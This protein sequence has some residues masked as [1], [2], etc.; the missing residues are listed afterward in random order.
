MKGYERDNLFGEID[1][2]FGGS[3]RAGGKDGNITGGHIIRV[4]F[5]S[6]A[7]AEFDY[8]VPDN[9]WPVKAGQRVEAPFGRNNKSEKGFCVAVDP[10]RDKTGKKFRLKIITNIIDDEP[11]WM[12]RCWNWRGG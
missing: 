2:R 10:V 12:V 6:G 9:L 7:D 11:R 3:E 4:A 5:E 8:L 1:F